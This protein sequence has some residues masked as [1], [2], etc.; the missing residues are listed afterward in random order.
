MIVVGIT[1]TVT[2]FAKIVKYYDNIYI[3][4]YYSY[5]Q[6]GRV[7]SGG[8]SQR[9]ASPSRLNNKKQHWSG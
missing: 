3:Y 4:L 5:Y 6:T 8:K 2:V 9:A 1:V 7:G